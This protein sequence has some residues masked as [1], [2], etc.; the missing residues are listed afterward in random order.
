[1]RTHNSFLDRTD[2]EFHVRESVLEQLLEFDF[3]DD[4]VLD[5]MHVVCLG[6]M[7]KL[8][9]HWVKR[10]TVSHLIDKDALARISRKLEKLGVNVPD[11]FCR[12]PRSLME[13]PRWKAQEQNSVNFC[14]IRDQ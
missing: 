9:K 2:P 11:E 14:F 10:D 7:R 1:M 4:V 5:Y 12:R 6:V 13:L 8:L 3:V